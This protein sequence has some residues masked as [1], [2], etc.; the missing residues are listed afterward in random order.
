MKN[1]KEK[2]VK[3]ILRQVDG[4]NILFVNDE[5]VGELKVRDEFDYDPGDLARDVAT[6][7]KCVGYLLESLSQNGNEPV[8]GWILYGFSQALTHYAHD[9]QGY[10][11]SRAAS[12]PSEP[13]I[14]KSPLELVP[15]AVRK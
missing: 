8:E 6:G 5:A 7:L 3:R 12:G 15:F 9:V 14:P 4:K 10:L 13:A 2:S 11:K 1:K